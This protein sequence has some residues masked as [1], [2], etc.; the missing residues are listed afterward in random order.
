MNDAIQIIKNLLL[1][2][3]ASIAF[4]ASKAYGA[5][6]HLLGHAPHKP[7]TIEDIKKIG[8]KNK[9]FAAAFVSGYKKGY[10]PLTSSWGNEDYRPIKI[11]PLTNEVATKQVQQFRN[12]L[13]SEKKN[14]MKIYKLR[15]STYNKLAAM[16]LGIFGNES[17]FGTSLRLK[18]K[19]NF[20]DLVVL[21]KMAKGQKDLTTSRGV[22]QI[23][24]LPEK[25]IEHYPDI[26]PDTLV[27]PGNAAIATMGYLTEA[28][29][30]LLARDDLKS[31]N[32]DNVFDYIPYVYSGQMH[33]VIKGT[34]TVVDNSYIIFMKR[35]IRKF[36]FMELK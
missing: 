34:A 18:V 7:H 25:I 24:D 2:L 35:N 5:N 16:A 33:K 27:N 3:V 30:M 28:F 26:S 19:E 10:R 8:S 1:P 36:Y 14:L 23:K 11:A 29:S 6:S 20:Q 15:N 4:S 32:A 22:T 9:V 13:E 31:I 21:G 12:A 17:E